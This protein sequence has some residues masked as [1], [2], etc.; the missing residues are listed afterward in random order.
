MCGIFWYQGKETHAQ[1]ILLNG[2]KRLEYRWYDSAGLLVGN[3]K[4]I[5]LVKAIGKVSNLSEKVQKEINAES[6]FSFGIAHTRWATHGGI[7]EN[8]THPHYDNKQQ[9]YLVHNGIIEN[10]L[11][12]F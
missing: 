5:K 2:L 4:E 8:N 3:Q 9:F 11:Q 7:T 1:N 12:G 6:Q 10:Y